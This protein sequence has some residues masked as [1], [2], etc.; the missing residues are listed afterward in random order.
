MVIDHIPIIQTINSSQGRRLLIS[1]SAHQFISITIVFIRL[2]LK[3]KLKSS[4][5]CLLFIWTWRHGLW[6]NLNFATTFG[7]SFHRLIVFLESP[8]EATAF[9]PAACDAVSCSMCKSTSCPY[10]FRRPF[11][12]SHISCMLH[13]C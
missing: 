3:N 1:W 2:S 7:S 10:S 6:V 4:I 11:E 5:G 13:T 9:V 12:I 8:N